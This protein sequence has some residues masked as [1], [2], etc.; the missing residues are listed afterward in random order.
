MRKPRSIFEDV[1]DGPAA[2]PAAPVTR[3]PAADRRGIVV[4][5]AVLFALVVAMIAMGGMTRLTGSGL[6]ITEWRPVTGA[7]PP[8]DAAAWEAEFAKYQ[9]SPQYQA[10]NQGMTLPE[11][12]SIYWW[13]WGH[14]QLGRIIGLVWGL[15]FLWFWLRRR[16]PPGWAPR[17]LGL[18]AL[19]GLQGAIGWWMVSS[20]LVAGMDS[21][22]SWRLAIHL[23]LAFL[24]LGLIAWYVLR[25]GRSEADLLQA[26]R[27]RNDGLIGWATALLVVAFVQILLGALVAGIDA[28][29]NFPQWPLMAGQL[30]PPDAFTET[31]LWRNFLANPGLVQFNHRI[32]GYVLFV[33]GL[34]AWLRSRKSA[35][36]HIR[37]AFA[38][39][40]AMMFVQLALGILTVMHAAPWPL[41]ILHQV[42][43]VA[44]FTLIVRSRFAALYPQAQRIARG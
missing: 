30:F 5:L 9:A 37:G 23:G 1:A 38:A 12:K 24:L 19:G 41:A 11:F 40:M 35:L 25:L 4:W 28:G 21:V 29:R 16:L 7:V 27:Q 15:G 34:T 10:V 33:L 14:R 43:A 31:P 26:R 42:G 18:G 20:G 17:L 2:A 32:A 44:L 3:R 8:L 6:S 36:V 13:E 22:A 39:M